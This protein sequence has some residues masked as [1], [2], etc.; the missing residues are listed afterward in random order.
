MHTCLKFLKGVQLQKSENTSTLRG[1]SRATVPYLY[2]GHNS[3]RTISLSR[4]SRIKW[5][6]MVK[7]FLLFWN[8]AEIS[9]TTITLYLFFKECYLYHRAAFLR[10]VWKVVREVGNSEQTS[11]LRVRCRASVRLPSLPLQGQEE[12]PSSGPFCTKTLIYQLK[13]C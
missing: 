1:R 4:S 6:Q 9:E 3:N 5:I 2:S 11:S 13:F 12:S 8:R 7:D 10:A